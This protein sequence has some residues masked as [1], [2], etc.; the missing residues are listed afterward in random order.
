MTQKEWLQ[1]IQGVWKECN[2]LK[3]EGLP[4]GR[5]CKLGE[6]KPDRDI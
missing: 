4:L 6:V 1:S 3:K 5:I 2:Y